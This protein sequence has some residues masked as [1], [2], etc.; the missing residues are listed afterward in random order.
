M[1]AWKAELI[2]VRRSCN[3]RLENPLPLP[4][5]TLPELFAHAWALVEKGEGPV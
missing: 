2:G 1:E 5:R 4:T 3:R